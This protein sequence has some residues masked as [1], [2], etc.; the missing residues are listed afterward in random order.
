M[1]TIMKK[2]TKE[3]IKKN[4]PLI[5]LEIILIINIIVNIFIGVKLESIKKVNAEETETTQNQIVNFNQL[6]NWYSLSN[7]YY[8]FTSYNTNYYS[9]TL[10]NQNIFWALIRINAENNPININ[11]KVY[12]KFI[13]LENYGATIKNVTTNADYNID[14]NTSIILTGGTDYRFSINYFNSNQSGTAHVNIML[15]DLTL[16]YGE[17]T[18]TLEE[19]EQIFKSE[20]YNYTT[21]TT[22][23]VNSLTEYANGY[24][25]GYNDA[26][27]NKNVE[28]QQASIGI[29]AFTFDNGIVYKGEKHYDSTWNVYYFNGVLGIPL[30]NTISAGTTLTFDFTF[31]VPDW[32][33]ES[34]S[35]KQDYYMAVGYVDSDNNLITIQKINYDN[36]EGNYVTYKG[37]VVYPVE[38]NTIYIW[39][40]TD[41]DLTNTLTTQYY[42]FGSTI[43]YI[44]DNV[45]GA[46]QSALLRGYENGISE[47]LPGTEK[48]NE[49][50]NLGYYNGSS[51]G[52]IFNDSWDFI[53][54]SFN[55]IGEIL[56][57]QLIPGL[58]IGLFV[59]LPLLVGLLFFIVKIAKG[60]GG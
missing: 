22:I 52:Q 3:T 23:N 59:A 47:Y 32:S 42:A 6:S 43:E 40:T 49:I 17:N 31:L 15:I 36:I 50:Y 9:V 53:K 14:V 58:P 29:N 35:Y 57:L 2:E 4:L 11:H 21:G 18:P 7:E 33:G 26:W 39:V 30:L 37:S 34:L 20:Y 46:I 25:N 55:G 38:T 13:S 8:N 60:S 41:F 56:G 16:M 19:C 10:T 1:A 44:T 54:L 51:G 28:I 48:Y 45:S 12:I 5:I 27:E 24:I